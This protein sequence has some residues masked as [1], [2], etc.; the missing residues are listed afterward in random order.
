MVDKFM[1]SYVDEFVR[2]YRRMKYKNK[3]LIY[4]IY[5]LE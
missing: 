3:P 5:G 1:D 4:I 2:Q